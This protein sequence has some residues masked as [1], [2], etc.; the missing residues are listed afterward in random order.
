LGV[1]EA[2]VMSLRS[3]P[4]DRPGGAAASRTSACSERM[5]RGGRSAALERPDAPRVVGLATAAPSS[6]CDSPRNDRSL[7]CPWPQ[8]TW[9]AD[10]ARVL[11]G[12]L[13]PA[14][15]S[16]KVLNPTRAILAAA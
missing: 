11:A 6:G 4:T 15:L 8:P 16:A 12:T 2:E 13:G 10:L 7:R 3:R 5:T 9:V 14:L 1:G